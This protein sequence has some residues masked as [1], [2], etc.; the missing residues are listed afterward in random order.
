MTDKQTLFMYRLTEAEETLAD[1]RNMLVNGVSARSIVNRAY[2][3]MF[4]SVIALLIARNVEHKTSK[5]SGIISIFDKE[6]VHTGMLGREFSRILHRT[7]DSRQE[8]DYKEFVAFTS[9]DAAESVRM[10]DE[11]LSGIKTLIDQDQSE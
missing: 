1:A 8:S 10:A 11:F 7:F 4:Y 3:A 5:H 6:I 9:E 2:Y